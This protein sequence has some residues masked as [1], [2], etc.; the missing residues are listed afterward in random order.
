M[1]TARAPPYVDTSASNDPKGTTDFTVAA[2]H[3]HHAEAD[4]A[5]FAELGLK[6]YRFSIAWTRIVPDGD[7]PVNRAG[8]AFYHRLFDAFPRQRHRT[9]RHRVPLRPARRRWTNGALETRSTVDASS[10]TRGS[11]LRNMAPRS[12]TG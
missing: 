11:S 2:D 6:A 12:G 10:G 9:G 8:V 1:R 4:G 7:G 3:Y 5:L